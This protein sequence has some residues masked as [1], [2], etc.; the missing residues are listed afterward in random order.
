MTLCSYG[1]IVQLIK[2]FAQPPGKVLNGLIKDVVNVKS[3]N[4]QD[5][6]LDSNNV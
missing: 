3:Y 2:N 4:T 1:K 5:S 6:R